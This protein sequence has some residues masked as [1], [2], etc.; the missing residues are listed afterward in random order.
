M[1]QIFLA[2][3]HER[4]AVQ[5]LVQRTARLLDREDLDGWLA[6]FDLNGEYELTAYST[7]LRRD[8]VWWKS[9]RAA[10]Q[11]ILAEVT[12]HVRDPAHRRR[13]LG[14]AVI[15]FTADQA[16]AE[17]AFAVYRTTREGETSLYAVGRYED[18][19]V[20]ASD[21]WLY[22]THRVVLDTRMLEMFTHLP[23]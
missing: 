16:Y 19:L 12:Q 23:L 4:H 7:E 18:S 20:R 22:R 11:K 3:Q 14:P 15:E 1:T 10:L 21:R 2:S 8:L 13:V 6:L 17:S 5:D 9:D